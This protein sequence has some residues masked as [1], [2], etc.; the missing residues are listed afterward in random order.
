MENVNQ[1]IVQILNEKIF[2]NRK[3]INQILLKIYVP[4]KGMYFHNWKEF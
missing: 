2:L 3:P 4:S 1:E